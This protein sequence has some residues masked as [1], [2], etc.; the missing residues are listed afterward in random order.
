M[1]AQNEYNLPV[2]KKSLQRIDRK[3][4]SH[5]CNLKNAVDLIAPQNT[6][7]LAAADGMM[8]FVHDDCNVGGPSPS[9]WNYANF[10]VISHSNGEYS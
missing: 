10:I 7:V 6:P 9:Y 5:F 3:S 2:P 8:T 4:P 1:I